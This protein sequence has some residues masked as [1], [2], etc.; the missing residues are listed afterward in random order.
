MVLIF[1]FKCTLKPISRQ[2]ILDWSKLK[3]STDDNIQLY[4]NSQ[5][6]SKWIENTVGKGEIARY[7]Q[8]LLF[9]QCFQKA[10]FPWAS[11]G[12]I[13]WEWVKMSSAICFNFHQS[14]ILLSVNGL[15]TKQ[16][17][18]MESAEF[19]ICQ[20]NTMNTMLLY[21]QLFFF[22]FSFYNQCIFILL[23]KF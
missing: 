2:Q 17:I 12:V 9:P 23:E 11:K 10:C 4:E 16:L 13:V 3:Q 21:Y 7:K 14:K 15:N 5:K 22:F 19:K 20:R 18:N 6:F 8:F 1:H